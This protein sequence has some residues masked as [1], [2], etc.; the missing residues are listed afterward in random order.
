MGTT[1]HAPSP[2][3]PCGNLGKATCKQNVRPWELGQQLSLRRTKEKLLVAV[4]TDVIS[5][6]FDLTQLAQGPIPYPA[7]PLFSVLCAL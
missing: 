7:C 6:C 5:Q 3:P 4:S 1:P 2:L